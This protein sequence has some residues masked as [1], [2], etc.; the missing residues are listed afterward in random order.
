LL[1]SIA[2]REVFVGTMSTIYSI[3]SVADEDNHTIKA[4]M[5]S[6][7]N[8]KTGQPMYTPALA[9]SLLIFY[10]FAMMCMSTIATVYRETHGWKWPI[11]QLVYMTVLAYGL[12]FLTYQ[13]LK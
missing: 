13:V 8:P 2:A 12:A 6:E 3:G 7:I 5:R 10:V 4:R 1:A 11:I 9:F